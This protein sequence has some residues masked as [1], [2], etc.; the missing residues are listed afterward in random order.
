MLLM[1]INFSQAKQA[2]YQ[3]NHP[4]VKPLEAKIAKNHKR[5]RGTS[6]LS[7][8]NTT[9]KSKNAHFSC[10]QRVFPPR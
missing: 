4:P 8:S 7:R 3:K 1:S 6:N 10:N 5:G 9:L 2:H